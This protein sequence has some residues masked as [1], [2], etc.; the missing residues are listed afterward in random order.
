MGQQNRIESPEMNKHLYGQLI[1]DNK[2][3]IYNKER[4]FL[5]KCCWGNC[6][7]II[8]KINLDYSYTMYKNKFKMG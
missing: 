2:A 4:Q 3:R 1:N 5:N 7:A 6:T 8:K